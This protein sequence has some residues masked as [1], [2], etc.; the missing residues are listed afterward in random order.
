MT[1]RDI[2]TAYDVAFRAQFHA[3]A[4]IIHGKDAK[5]A[6]GLV[7]RYT[8][9][10]LER[11]LA[12]FCRSRD[13]FIV[14]S[15]YSFGVFVACLGKLIVAEARQ[16]PLVEGGETWIQWRMRERDAREGGR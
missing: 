8:L 14:S 5:L 11:Y 10:E 16:V 2:L 3:P 7:G 6:K 4:P 12:L 15:T 1:P 13:S 9:P